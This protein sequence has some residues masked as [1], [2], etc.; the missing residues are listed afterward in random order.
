MVGS[1]SCH[2]IQNKSPPIIFSLAS[3]GLGGILS[4]FVLELYRR[5]WQGGN[6]NTM[7]CPMNVNSNTIELTVRTSFYCILDLICVTTFS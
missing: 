7:L 4:Q 3:L 5:K 2:R 6:I 1:R